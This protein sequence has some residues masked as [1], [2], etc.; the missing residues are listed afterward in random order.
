MKSYTIKVV[1]MKRFLIITVIALFASLGNSSAQ[2]FG[3]KTN[4]LYLA[5]T[6]PNI[7]I[8]FAVAPRWTI[9]I[10]GGYNP[11]TLNVADN[12]KIKHWL[13]SPEIRYWF[14]NAFQGH[15]LGLNGNYTQFN[16][17]ALPF[18]AY[19]NTRI[20][21]WAAGAGLT[22]GYAFP[23]ARRWNMELTCGLGVW[24]TE[25]DQYESRKCG[26]FQQQVQKFAF[27]PTALGLS[28][29]YMIK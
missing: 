21:G 24:Y 11:W 2:N 15:F 26:L 5:T 20:E 19:R 12:M 25:Y 18:D 13:V 29:V 28:F 17:G 7:G 9:D 10:E 8:E 14:C 3:V 4:A 22:Y 1:L 23:I 27:G 16:I 6:T